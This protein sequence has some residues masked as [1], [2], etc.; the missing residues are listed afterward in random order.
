[1]D[2]SQGKM[3]NTVAGVRNVRGHMS[4]GYKEH[5]IAGGIH[6]GVKGVA[7]Q[8]KDAQDTYVWL[9]PV[10]GIIVCGM[11]IYS[12]S[13]SIHQFNKDK[14]DKDKTKKDE[15]IVNIVFLSVYCF[16]ALCMLIYLCVE[17]HKHNKND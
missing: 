7:Q 17:I 1:M 10:L 6:G 5:G 13:V 12:T 16:V 9:T 11:G 15:N 14:D 3:A 2:P 4:A 8:Y